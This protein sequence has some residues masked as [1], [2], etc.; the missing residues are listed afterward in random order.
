[1]FEHKADYPTAIASYDDDGVTAAIDWCMQQA[2]DAETMSVWT[3]LKSNLQNSAALQAFVHRHRDVEHIT[4]RGDGMPSAAGPV[5]M[6]WADMNDI[7]RL[8]RHAQRVRA[9][10]VIAW[11]EERI[12]PWVTA[13]NPTVLGDPAVWN[14]RS[15]DVSPLLVEA[16]KSL[17]GRINHNNTISAGYEKNHVVGTLLS[18]HDAEIPMNADAIQA[19]ALANGWAGRNPEQLAQ[20]VCEIND[21]KRPR[22]R[23]ILR[24]D[25]IET[26]RQRA[27][28]NSPRR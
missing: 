5:L 22:H 1:M 8:L 3:S 27:K 10:C 7:G 11:N 14:T 28:E 23:N 20:Y 19:W 9:L 18:L 2:A 4:G 25:Y 21:G 13:I 6:A 16:L 26:L 15:P 12:R 17:T 24:N